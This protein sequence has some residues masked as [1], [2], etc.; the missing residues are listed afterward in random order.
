MDTR[1]ENIL[2]IHGIGRAWRKLTSEDAMEIQFGL[3]TGLKG[4]ELAD[5]YHVSETTVSRIKH[6]RNFW[7]LRSAS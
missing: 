2:D 6:G 4:R 1:T 5:M 3:A 7:W